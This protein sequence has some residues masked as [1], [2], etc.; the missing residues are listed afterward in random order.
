MPFIHKIEARA[1]SRATE[2]SE[3][4]I[5]AILNIFPEDVRRNVF[6]SEETAEG[7]SGDTITII[8]GLLDKKEECETSLDVLFR[9]MDK[10][11]LRAIKRTLDLRVDTSCVCFLRIDKQ[12]A[13]L[14]KLRLADSADV[15]R[16]MIHFKDSP[17]CKQNDAIKLIEER[18]QS[19]ED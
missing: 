10:K 1:Y 6:L 7:Q 16:V 2:V 5:T 11:D 17:R 4:V 9:Q 15:I 14:G 12:G 19:A 8:S 18:L 3:R 13:Y